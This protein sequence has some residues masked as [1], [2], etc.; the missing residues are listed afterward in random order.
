MAGGQGVECFPLGR[1]QRAVKSVEGRAEG[2]QGRQTRRHHV[3]SLRQALLRANPFGMGVIAGFA[4]CYRGG[5]QA[6]RELLPRR[7]LRA[8]EL[9]C[10]LDEID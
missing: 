8:L 10:L 1:R 4:E 2:L 6:F 3:L 9:K 7:R 5:P